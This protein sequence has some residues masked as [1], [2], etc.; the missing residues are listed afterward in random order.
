MDNDEDTSDDDDDDDDNHE[1]TSIITPS[2]FMEIGLR[3]VGFKECRIQRAQPATNIDRFK[4]FF[5]SSPRVIA[6]IWEDLQKTRINEAQVPPQDR[7]I[8]YFL[9]AMHHLQRYPTEIER[10]G[11]FDISAMWGRD[12]V[13]YFVEKVQALKAEKI[14]WPNDY[15]GDD[16]W[17]L[18]VDGTH[19]W[20]QEPQ[21]P[22]WSQDKSYYSH[23]YAKAGMNYELGISLSESKLLWMNGPFK[24]GGNDKLVLKNKGLKT[25][26]LS[27]GKKAIGDCGY[28]GHQTAVVCPNPRDNRK[29]AK[30]KSRALK[31]HETFNGRTKVFDCLS[32]RFRHSTD[33]FKNCFEAVCVIVQYQIEID[34]P[35]F[36]IIVEGM[37]D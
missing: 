25:K 35:M 22:T 15:G 12:W 37:F 21:H 23:K 1:V 17:V 19:C 29:V 20:I 9:M 31:R 33:R 28:F 14:V 36:D 34:D 8:K 27:L 30:F 11:M 24:A 16:I 7:K 10:E 18:S 13:W 4:S 5:G 26:L 32:G 3:L 2:E 6:M